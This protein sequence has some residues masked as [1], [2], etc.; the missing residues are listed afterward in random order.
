MLAA[1]LPLRCPRVDDAGA[2]RV[3]GHVQRD[4]VCR[5]N[6]KLGSVS[7]GAFPSE[8]LMQALA[9]VHTNILEQLYDV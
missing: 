6:L 4:G 3:A 7:A 8:N 9:G 5:A 1:L 2:S